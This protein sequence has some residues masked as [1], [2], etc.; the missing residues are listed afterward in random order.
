[1][2]EQLPSAN[3]VTGAASNGPAKNEGPECAGQEHSGQRPGTKR[4]LEIGAVC[5]P[6]SKQLK[7]LISERDA[8]ALD[9]H[10]DAINHCYVLGFMDQR[11]T[12]RARKKLIALCQKAVSDYRIARALK[13]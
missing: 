2:N 11:S 13:K 1:M 6:L 8:I 9:T 5:D 12:D 7:G 3:A 4:M 10:N